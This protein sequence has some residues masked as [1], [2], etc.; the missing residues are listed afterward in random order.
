MRTHDTPTWCDRRVNTVSIRSEVEALRKAAKQLL[1][2]A[3]ASMV[4]AMAAFSTES[5]TLE[6]LDNDVWKLTL[7]YGRAS[8]AFAATQALP[9]AVSPTIRVGRDWYAYECV[10]PD[11]FRTRCGVLRVARPLYRLVSGLGPST[12]SPFDRALG[13]GAGRMSLAFQSISLLLATMLPFQLAKDV[14]QTVAGY[15]P[16]TKSML[17]MVDLWGPDAA[18]F[19]ETQEAPD[20]D[21]EILMIQIDGKGAPMMGFTEHAKRCRPHEKR[22]RG[23]T[24]GQRRRHRLHRRGIERR[25]KG[26][27]S[28][29]AKNAT[30]LVVYTLRRHEDGTMEGP[31]NKRLIAGFCSPKALVKRAMPAVRARGYGEKETYFISDGAPCLHK[32]H[33]K[34]FPKAAACLD[35]YHMCEYLWIAGGTMYAKSPE[36][37]SNW[38]EARKAELRLGHVDDALAAIAELEAELP[39]TGPGTKG[40]RERM[41]KARKYLVKRR[42]LL[43]YQRF[44]AAGVDIGSGAVEGAAKYAVG[45][46]FDGP[47]MYWGRERS[48]QLL[49]L[50]AVF[51]NGDWEE[52]YKYVVSERQKNNSPIVPRITPNKTQT[53][54]QAKSK[55]A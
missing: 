36:D 41:A 24:R 46:R 34:F 2:D 32:V 14:Q 12:V 9:T 10:H 40:R 13:L 11:V 38:V 35:W 17:G 21:G 26:K 42:H 25:D 30:M 4:D 44:L 8:I 33:E 43:C 37:L 31:I 53:P 3:H 50:R 54:Y 39:G 49:Q 52:F 27:K 28:K 15:S 18:R 45:A 5:G 51:V 47:G 48:E 19:L 1:D 7:A 55:V 16:S 20:D 23:L 22:P 6:S 29:N